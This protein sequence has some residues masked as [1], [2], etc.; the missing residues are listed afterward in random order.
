[1]SAN[2]LHGGKIMSNTT[3]TKTVRDDAPLSVPAGFRRATPADLTDRPNGWVGPFI[4]GAALVNGRPQS[5]AALTWAPEG[6]LTYVLDEDIYP[7]DSNDLD[8]A[9]NRLEALLKYAALEAETTSPAELVRAYRANDDCGYNF[10]PPW[11]D[12]RDLV[13]N[14]RE[15]PTLNA[16]TVMGGSVPIGVHLTIALEDFENLGL[17]VLAESNLLELT[18]TREE[19]A[20]AAELFATMGRKLTAFLASEPVE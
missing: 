13:L 19:I 4:Y 15:E 16:S 20:A 1:M 17:D 5:A 10:D 2:P 18:G 3:T 14:A 7:D 12:T 6:G 9:L 8:D 11:H